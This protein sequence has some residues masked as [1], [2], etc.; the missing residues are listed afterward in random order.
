MKNSHKWLWGLGIALAIAA[1]AIVV[2]WS[3]SL[4]V[5]DPKGPV[6]EIQKNLIWIS[7]ILCAVIIVPVLGIF[8]FIIVRYRDKP[9]NKAPYEPNW[10]HSTKLEVI[11]WGIPIVIVVLL[12]YYTVR[13]TYK[14]VKP[15]AE[16]AHVAPVTIQVTSMDWKWLF[17][18]PDQDIATINYINIPENT[19]IQFVLT[20]SAAMNS[21]W[22]PQL[23]GQTYAMPGMAMRMWLQADETG[24][25]F[26]SGA[27][28]TGTDF[29]KMNFTVKSMSQDD[30]NDW[31]SK[32]QQETA[33]LDNAAYNKLSVK[34]TADIQTFGSMD[35]NLFSSIVIKNGGH[36]HPANGLDIRGAYPVKD[37][38]N[39]SSGSEP[40]AANQTSGLSQP[41]MNH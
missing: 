4:M 14:L 30:F 24:E 32:S 25:Y 7:V 12:G 33:K 34:G 19:P 28:F 27:N 10:S 16:T 5:L 35:P 41:E 39:E 21:F 26:G 3:G 31:V 1:V 17:Q 9:D 6:A 11:W 29:A 38:N 2:V 13:D 20:S 37:G 18:Y 22:I 36:H 40:D 15:P 8:A 23:G